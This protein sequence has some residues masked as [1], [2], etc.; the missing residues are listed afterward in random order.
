VSRIA[1]PN[2]RTSESTR[3]SLGHTIRWE[4][5]KPIAAESFGLTPIRVGGILRF[6]TLTASIWIEER[7]DRISLFLAN[8]R[9][10]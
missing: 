4:N 1:S 6:W 8:L 10:A 2:K 9:G 3:F 5:G 7:A